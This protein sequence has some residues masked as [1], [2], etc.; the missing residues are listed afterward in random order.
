MTIL[1]L[2]W[3]NL[4]RNKRRT[5]ITAISIALGCVFALFIFALGAGVH[6]KTIEDSTRMLAGQITIEHPKY[7]D[8]PGPGLFVPSVARLRALAATMPDVEQV[9]PLCVASGVV[10]TASGATPI[11]LL[12][13]EPEQERDLSL[14][15]RSMVKGRFIAS[16]DASAK[17]VVVG[18]RLADRLR[19]DIG[20]KLVLTTTNAQ[21]EV[22]EE[23]LRV[24]GIFKLGSDAMDGDFVEVPIEV[25]RRVMGLSDD[26]ATQVG[27]LLHRPDAQPA[28]L[29]RTQRALAAENLAVYP[30]ETL[31]PAL[32]TW[33]SF[34]EKRHHLVCGVVLF[35]TTF[36][37][38]N[39]ILMSILERRREFA[40]LLALGTP[41]RMLRTQVFVETVLVAFLGCAIGLVLGCAI[42]YAT[43][44]HGIDMSQV[45]Q[46]SERPTVGRLPVDL[47]LRP[48]LLLGDALFV[49]GTVFV[50]TTLIAIYPTLRSSRVDVPGTLRA[51]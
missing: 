4:F 15:A 11:A 48:A 25:A 31:L 41:P 21:G 46:D 38:L 36:T 19:V 23:L 1:K 35:M 2:A 33:V 14:V 29:E 43:Q 13:V 28:V 51:Q 50:V 34:G 6:K 16:S 7:R 44:R 8:E 26:Q 47:H 37:I 24:V 42:A 20:N 10:A 39:T 49:V 22:V 32:A 18:T 12:G 17:G 30:W 9:K 27:F 3:R 40:M 5:L 45:I